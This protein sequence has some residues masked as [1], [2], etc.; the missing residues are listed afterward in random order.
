MKNFIRKCEVM[1]YTW[2]DSNTLLYHWTLTAG[3]P[4][5]GNNLKLDRAYLMD[6]K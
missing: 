3:T 5:R 4:S 6:S 1:S 2:K